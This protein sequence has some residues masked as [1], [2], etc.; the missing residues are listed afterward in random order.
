M[1]LCRGVISLAA[2]VCKRGRLDLLDMCSESVCSER[3]FS[4][5]YYGVY[6][7]IKENE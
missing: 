3:I 6:L 2:V 4:V 5:K 1:K 7:I